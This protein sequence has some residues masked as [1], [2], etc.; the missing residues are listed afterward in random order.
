M[1]KAEGTDGTEER[2]K[3]FKPGDLNLANL[4]TLSRILVSPLFVYLLR[5]YRRNRKYLAAMLF[6]AAG[7]TDYLDGQVARK[8]GMVTRLGQFLD[9]L[10]DKVYISTPLIMLAWLGRVKR[11][12]PAVIIG[13]EAVITGFRIYANRQGVSVPA[14]RIAKLKTN[15]QILAIVLLMLDFRI[16]DSDR[17]QDAAVWLAVFLTVY[18]GIN[19]IVNIERYLGRREKG[20]A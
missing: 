13:R 11:W 20:T 12:V 2:E 9:P 17:H 1:N 19:Y 14:T 8:R 18:S 5:D 10:A 4:L 6:A 16:N 3:L 7:L 15:A